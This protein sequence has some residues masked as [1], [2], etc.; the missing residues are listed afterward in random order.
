MKQL[1]ARARAEEGSYVNKQTSEF[2][3]QARSLRQLG[4]WAAKELMGEGAP[5]V[6]VYAEALVRSGIAGNDAFKNVEDDLR[7][8][9]RED[10]SVEV[11]S[12]F[13]KIL[14]EA[15]QNVG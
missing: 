3:V 1:Q 13:Q 8:A 7:L 11:T 2:L 9:G 4:E 10:C 5:G 6:A 15:R 14:D 12:R